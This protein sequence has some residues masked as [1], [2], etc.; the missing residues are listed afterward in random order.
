MVLAL[1]VVSAP[2]FVAVPL[3]EVKGNA[4][5]VRISDTGYVAISTSEEVYAWQGGKMQWRAEQKKLDDTHWQRAFE[6]NVVS[7]DGTVGGSFGTGRPLFMSGLIQAHAGLLKDG[8]LIVL[9]ETEGTGEVTD[10]APDGTAIG[11]SRWRG[12]TY[13]GGKVSV[14]KTVTRWVGG[15]RGTLVAAN[16]K[17]DYLG[18]SSRF[19]TYRD[20]P[21]VYSKGKYTWLLAG[22]DPSYINVRDFNA[23]GTVVAVQ[24]FWNEKG[25]NRF[26]G[27]ILSTVS[28]KRKVIK[29]ALFNAINDRGWIVGQKNQT[30][31]VW[32]DEVAYDL[33][34]VAPTDA[35]WVRTEAQ[36]I[37]RNGSIVGIEKNGDATRPFL[38]RLKSR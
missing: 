10:F 1:L 9:E 28:S 32:I 36:G 26:E 7:N 6:V 3:V 16:S 38:L 13:R 30:A 8:K 19:K 35:G 24:G 22:F 12:F 37:N 18:T 11:S 15:N 14:W 17:G 31:M 29:D 34:V 20:T 21:F 33:N 5:R 23:D 25:L 27:V 4:T 2:S